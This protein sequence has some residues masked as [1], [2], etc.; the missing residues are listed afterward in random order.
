M[1]DKSNN[2]AEKEVSTVK[3]EANKTDKSDDKSNNTA[4]K[5]VSTVKAEANKTDKA[6]ANKTDK[7]E[8]NKTDKAVEKKPAKVTEATKETQS[9]KT[10]SGKNASSSQSSS[11]QK[12]AFEKKPF[13]GNR[14]NSSRNFNNNRRQPGGGYNRRGNAAGKQ[15]FKSG[16]TGSDRGRNNRNFGYDNSGFISQIVKTRRVTAVTKG[17]RR[18][19][20]SALVVAGNYKGEIGYASGKAK[21]VPGAIKKAAKKA[22][23]DV[24]TVKLTDVKSILFPVTGRYK[25]SRVK[26]IPAPDGA[27]IVAGGVVRTAVELAGI[28]NIY[29]KAMYSRN[30]I[31]TLKAVMN[32]F[33][34]LYQL[35]RRINL[36]K[37]KG[38]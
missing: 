16:R 15:N 11:H 31:N 25:N 21:E 3:A 28:K 8:A 33:D 6:E 32:A 24:V 2:T 36:R 5:E 27:G 30:P 12:G 29:S 9:S 18:M 22:V 37:N 14:S 13:S 4:E 26:L 17:G 34:Q 7:A 20:F 1:T 19:S 38:Q 23:K 35:E 10:D